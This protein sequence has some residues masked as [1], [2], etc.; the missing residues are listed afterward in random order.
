LF[1]VA[2]L[3]LLTLP[4]VKENTRSHLWAWIWRI[5]LLQFGFS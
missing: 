5:P 1:L 3:L 4:L 2:F